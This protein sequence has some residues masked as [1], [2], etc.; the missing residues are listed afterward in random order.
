MAVVCGIVDSVLEKRDYPG[1]LW[2][3]DDNRSDDNP[4]INGLITLLN[5][6]ITFQN[7][8]PISLYVSIEFVRTAQ[9]AFIYFDPDIMYVKPG[10]KEED[11]KPT[12]ARSWNLADDLGQIEYI[13]SDKTGTLTQV[14]VI[15]RVIVWRAFSYMPRTV[16]QNSMEFRQCS[17][18]GVVYHG[19]GDIHP[20]PKSPFA[21]SRSVSSD[22]TAAST[23]QPRPAVQETFAP[24]M[25][26]PTASLPRVKL[27][28]GVITHFV[29]PHITA[30]IKNA[31]GNGD[32]QAKLLDEFFICLSL[33]HSVLASVDAEGAVSYKAQSPDEAALVQ[34]AA[35]T[36]YIF[37]GRD[38]GSQV[39]RMRT[40]HVS[41]PKRYELLN[42]LD[43]TSTRKR[44]SVILRTLDDEDGHRILLLC[45]G[46]DNVIFERL[47]PRTGDIFKEK[48]SEDLE[49]FAGEGLRTLCLAQRYLSGDVLVSC[50][51]T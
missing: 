39:L 10:Q 2:L 6:F 17:V 38:P 22:D 12:L 4:S 44:M 30:D 18:G 14:R 42:L 25:A 26:D 36:G 19:E 41:E 24:Q 5:A 21:N 11:G 1:A 49:M 37:L 46:A 34:A 43:F 7:V 3:Y 50:A 31:H 40:P 8:I 45:K 33:C 47:E 29:D 9:A 27:S 48:T 15:I 13:F 51:L 20:A 28:D 35:D 32:A 16:S 23:Q